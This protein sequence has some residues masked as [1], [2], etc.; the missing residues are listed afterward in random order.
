MKTKA[1]FIFFSITILCKIYIWLTFLTLF[2]AANTRS[3][4]DDIGHRCPGIYCI[5]CSCGRAYIGQTGRSIAK[6]LKEHK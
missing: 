2:K 6:Q 4:K 1:C 5:P 3:V